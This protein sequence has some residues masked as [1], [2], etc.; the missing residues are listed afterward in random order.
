MGNCIGTGKATREPI[1]VVNRNESPA[2]QNFKITQSH[3]VKEKLTDI[4]QD[5]NFLVTLGQ[6]KSDKKYSTLILI[7]VHMEK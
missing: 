1:V 6:G 2:L 5:Y 4:N 7:Q 3:L